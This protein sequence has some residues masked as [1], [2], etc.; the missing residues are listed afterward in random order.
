MAEATAA[1]TKVAPVGIANFRQAE[2]NS[3]SPVVTPAPNTS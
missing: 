2:C 3:R 1:G